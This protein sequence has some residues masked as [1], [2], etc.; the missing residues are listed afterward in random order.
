MLEISRKVCAERILD[1]VV[2]SSQERL[3]NRLQSV[4]WRPPPHK[5]GERRSPLC[6][7]LRQLSQGLPQRLK[8]CPGSGAFLEKL[9]DLSD[10]QA[11]LDSLKRDQP[12]CVSKLK[13]VIR[14]SHDFCASNLP[15]EFDQTIS[16]YGLKHREIYA[17][18]RIEQVNKIGRYWGSCVYMAK[19][20][21]K[22]PGIFKNMQMRP[23]LPYQAIKS[24]ISFKDKEVFCH[25]HAEIQLV[26]FYGHHQVSGSLQ[27]RVV[28][29]SKLACY[30]CSLFIVTQGNFFLTK[31]HGRLYDQWNVPDL[32]AYDVSQRREYRHVLAK[33][34]EEIKRTLSDR[35]L[36]PSRAHPM[37]S[38]ANLPFNRK[39]SPLGSEAVTL[40]ST[41]ELPLLSSCDSITPSPPRVP[42][43]SASESDSPVPLVRNPSILNGSTVFAGSLPEPSASSP[44]TAS[45]RTPVPPSSPRIFTPTGSYTNSIP[46]LPSFILPTPNLPCL[47]S[48]TIFPTAPCVVTTRKICTEIS[49]DGAQNPHG[50][51][52][53]QIQPANN[54]LQTL[55]PTALFVDLDGLM[56]PNEELKLE[57]ADGDDAMVLVLK[58]ERSVVL[59]MKLSWIES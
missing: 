30:L 56:P 58:L 55:S 43:H 26:T 13:E 37:T 20:S 41:S 32:A 16:K 45:Q 29:T 44:T 19:A 8:D 23:L 49:L 51:A 31:T 34:N 9:G 12:E 48:H 50:K 57:R 40:L 1:V 6:E 3:H 27:P 7:G 21:K 17:D 25:V 38:S 47:I 24:S 52:I 22:Y 10:S 39:L 54:P 33:M 15:Q 4:H 46:P 35:T 42:A 36:H 2:E 14:K 53:V 59:M 28:G 18:K 5:R 11:Q